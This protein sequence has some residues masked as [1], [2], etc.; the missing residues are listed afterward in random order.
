MKSTRQTASRVVLP[1]FPKLMR[2]GPETRLGD[3]RPRLGVPRA[4]RG[5]AKA[6][7]GVPLGLGPQATKEGEP[8]RF[9][10]ADP[11]GSYVSLT[12]LPKSL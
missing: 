12:K 5:F 9:L 6:R 2:E 7:V 4:G 11:L 3:L 8:S 1:T 10:F